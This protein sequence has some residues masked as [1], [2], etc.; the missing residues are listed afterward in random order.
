MAAVE[1]REFWHISCSDKI[2]L[3]GEFSQGR[4]W[5]GKLRYVLAGRPSFVL[6]GEGALGRGMAGMARSGMFRQGRF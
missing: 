1:G 3:A 2:D 4:F 5:H 6:A